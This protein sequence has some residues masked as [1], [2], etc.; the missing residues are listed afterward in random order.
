MEYLE[1]KKEIE[2]IYNNRFKKSKC[3]V[4]K[5]AFTSTTL[6]IQL[7]LVNAETE[8]INGIL[9]NDMF[10]FMFTLET[11]TDK[12]RAVETIDFS[13][14]NLVLSSVNNFY[15]II[16][17][18]Q[19]MAY[20]SKKVNFRKTT[21]NIDKILKSFEKFVDKLYLQVT[22]S[23]ENGEIHKNY[24]DLLKSKI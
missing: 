9:Q 20:S 13:K 17:D 10:H 6:F 8:S 19:Y 12:D 3:V 7:Y 22:E 11:E 23:I 5:G 1:L 2:K 24:I 15:M 16:P 18:N 21:G 4:S 14:E